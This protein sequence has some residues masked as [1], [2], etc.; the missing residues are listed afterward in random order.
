MSQNHTTSDGILGQNQINHTT[1]NTVCQN[2]GNAP[3][4]SNFG[5]QK[6][7]CNLAR[8]FPRAYA[9]SPKQTRVCFVIHSLHHC[10]DP[11]WYFFLWYFWAACRTSNLHHKLT[12][13]ASNMTSSSRFPSSSS[14]GFPSRTTL[15]I[16]LPTI[17]PFG[18]DGNHDG[19]WLP[20]QIGTLRIQWHHV[21]LSILTPFKHH[22]TLP[23]WHQGQRADQNQHK[24]FLLM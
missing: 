2:H 22:V 11:Y 1:L 5:A 20:Q 21:T 8:T 3:W 9:T 10:S 13:Q 23:L 24:V 7:I 15:Y 18:L 17:S 12:H 6:T 4:Y 19:V 14:S 16:I